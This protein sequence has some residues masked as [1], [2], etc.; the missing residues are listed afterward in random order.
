MMRTY[1]LVIQLPTYNERLEYLRLNG[2]VGVDTFGTN[3]YVNQIFY[4]SD[5]WKKIRIKAIIRD[6]GCDLA[7][8]GYDIYDSIIVHHINPITLEDILN[9]NPKIFDLNNLI[10]VSKDT[11]NAIHYGTDPIFTKEVITRT[12]NDTCPWRL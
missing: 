12:K 7:C 3:R 4:N 9:R 6:C 8:K 5:E 10:T 1:S 2:N 11:H